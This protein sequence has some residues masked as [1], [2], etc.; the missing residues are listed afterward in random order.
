MRVIATILL[1]LVIAWMLVKYM[2]NQPKPPPRPVEVE[3]TEPAILQSSDRRYS[4]P[5]EKA[6]NT[7][8]VLMEGVDKKRK[9]IEAATQ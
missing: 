1:V 7:E 5:I 8:A 4:S 3:F 2:D 9:E 6:K